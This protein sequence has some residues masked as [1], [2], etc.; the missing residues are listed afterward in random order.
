MPEKTL[1]FN[2]E[3]IIGDVMKM[4]P[5][6]E[7]V[8]KKYFGNGCFTCPGMNMEALSFGAMMHNMDPD[9]IVDELNQLG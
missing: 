5:G 6:A 4:H 8:I 7:A 1:R 3:M 2:K 9:L